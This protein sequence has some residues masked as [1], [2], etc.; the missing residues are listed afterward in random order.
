MNNVQIIQLSENQRKVVLNARNI[1]CNKLSKEEFVK[2]LGEDLNNAS[3]NYYEIIAEEVAKSKERVISYYHEKYTKE[4]E[5]RYKRKSN[6]ERYFNELFEKEMNRINRQYNQEQINNSF[7]I[8]IEFGKMGRDSRTVINISDLES[9]L[10]DC[11]EYI[12]ENNFWVNAN[13]WSIEYFVSSTSLINSWRITIKLILPEELENEALR[14]NK[15]LADSVS[16]FYSNSNY[17][18]D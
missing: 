8:D 5:K 11:F 4:A 6:Q 2:L 12:K 10:N 7:E 13:G 9:N 3:D 17:W 14:L 1:E 18:G 15:E 16:R